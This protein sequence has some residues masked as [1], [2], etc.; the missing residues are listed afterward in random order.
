MTR[1]QHDE[2]T[3]H[4]LVTE[5]GAGTYHWCRCGKTQTVPYCDGSHAAIG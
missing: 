4:L 1:F 2:S 3:S 5:L